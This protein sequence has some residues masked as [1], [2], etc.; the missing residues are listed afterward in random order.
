M[1][2]AD[3][4]LRACTGKTKYRIIFKIKMCFAGYFGTENW[5]HQLT[6]IIVYLSGVS[7]SEKLLSEKRHLTYKTLFQYLSRGIF[8]QCTQ[9]D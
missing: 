2:T 5:R 3:N 1:A 8:P 7:C 4:N 9:K 6:L